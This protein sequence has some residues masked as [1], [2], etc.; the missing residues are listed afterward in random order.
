MAYVLRTVGDP[1]A[2]AATVRAAVARVDPAVPV[3]QMRTVESYLSAQLQGQR[4][5]ATLFG[6]FAAVALG[7]G[8]Q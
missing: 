3:V 4:F 5:M 8:V 6:I 1:M 2:L 7:I